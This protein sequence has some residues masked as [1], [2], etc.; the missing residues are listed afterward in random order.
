MTQQGAGAALTFKDWLLSAIARL[1]ADLADAPSG[2]ANVR[3]EFAQSL[4]VLGEL[5]A[6][7]KQGAIAVTEA[8]A[9][10]GPGLDT[11]LALQSHGVTLNEL[12]E[13]DAA[14]RALDESQRMLD[15]L[16]VSD[17]VRNHRVAGRTTL[18]RIAG[19]RGD[20]ARA[21]E[22]AQQNID[23]RGALFGADSFRLA[24]DYNNLSVFLMRLGRLADAE[25]ATLR[26]RELLQK[27]P[28]HP[29][30]RVAYM[31]QALC[32]LRIL[33]GDGQAAI[34]LCRR[35]VA[36]SEKVVGADSPQTQSQRITLALALLSAGQVDDADREMNDLMPTISARETRELDEALSMAAL[37]KM[38]QQRWRA[39]QRLAAEAA[40]LFDAR[41]VKAGIPLDRVQ[42]ISALAT[43]A[44]R[45]TAAT[46]ARLRS[47]AAPVIART[48]EPGV[49]RAFAALCVHQ[50]LLASGEVAEADI[51]HSQ[52]IELL[53]HDM[54]A[55]T[56]ERQWA[57]WTVNVP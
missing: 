36:L 44:L 37:I 53:R 19:Y 5:S 4:R 52:A 10:F 22:I 34:E 45:P 15:A 12:G 17:E 3:R 29:V 41:G 48:T 28:A 31:D 21:L 6:A 7:A 14:Q 13:H 30:A 42:L 56:A 20:Y 2:R 18:V 38:R 33:R 9:I 25:R 23:E 43:H 46:L 55:A 39:A 51:L 49:I 50:G 40:A 24:V 54:D 35:A 57:N 27:D 32:S 8:R 16:P 47:R 11:A 1:D 26:A